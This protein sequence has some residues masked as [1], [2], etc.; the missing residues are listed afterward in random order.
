[1]VVVGWSI[2]DRLV[3][4]G[5]RLVVAGGGRDGVQ[6]GSKLLGPPIPRTAC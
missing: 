5:C 1:M 6:F 2:V 4:A 3:L